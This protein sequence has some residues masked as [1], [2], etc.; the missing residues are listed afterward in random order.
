MDMA[1]MFYMEYLIT[2]ASREGARYAAR[3]TYP[4]NSPTSEQISTYVTSTL[5]YN[6]FNLS[7]FDVSATYDGSPP[8]ETVT[9][10]AK[11]T[12]HWWILGSLF[13][14]TKHLEAKTAMA[15]E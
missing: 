8:N 7:D 9:V 12:K 11:A 5:K 14:D 1:H 13:G 4:T 10:T 15:V 2:N 3:Y 6:S